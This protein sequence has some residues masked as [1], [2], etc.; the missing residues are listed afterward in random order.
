MIKIPSVLQCPEEIRDC[1]IEGE[2]KY[3][4]ETSHYSYH[5]SQHYS[6]LGVGCFAYNTFHVWL[7]CSACL[8]WCGGL[9]KKHST[10]VH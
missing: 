2:V 3:N 6:C 4:M 8:E 7:D 10:S 9:K 1:K 5:Q